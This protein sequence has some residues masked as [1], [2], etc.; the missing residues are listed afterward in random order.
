MVNSRNPFENPLTG[1]LL[2]T[3]G[4]DAS[5]AFG[6]RQPDAL[7][8]AIADLMRAAGQSAARPPGPTNNAFAGLL[9]PSVPAEN[10][11]GSRSSI[12]QTLP[13]LPMTPSVSQRRVFFSFHYHDVNRVN[14]VRQSGKIRPI[15]RERR[16]TVTDKSLWERSRSTNADALKQSINRALAGTSVTCILI[17]EHTWA[18]PWVRYEIARSLLIGNGIF[19][20]RIDRLWC[21]GSRSFGRFGHNPLECMAVGRDDHGRIYV[22]EYDGYGWVKFEQMQQRLLRWPKWLADVP[23]GHL[24]PL[25]QGASVYDYQTDCGSDRLLIWANAVAKAAGK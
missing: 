15:D 4:L 8:E 7:V 10:A 21:I 23:K 24:R 25:D 3:A 9:G 2:G 18:R 17:G 14:V 16:K 6:R 13:S 19:G 20:V 22:F 1:G 11:F 12:A 5:D